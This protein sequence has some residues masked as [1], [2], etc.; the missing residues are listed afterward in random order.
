VFLAFGVAGA[1]GSGLLA[2]RLA[3]RFGI[4]RALALGS[5]LLCLMPLVLLYR[6]APAGSP[7]ML[8][9]MAGSILFVT[10]CYGPAFAVIEAEL[11]EL[12]KATVTG[13][14]MLLINVLM[15]GG[16]AVLIGATSD[17]LLAEGSAASW[18]IPL[19]AADLL[20]SL[21]ILCLFAAARTRAGSAISQ[22]A[23]LEAGR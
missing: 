18:T 5:A 20:A 23:G 14:N 2:D 7:V 13:L 19:L 11:P 17:R 22:P 21:G 1:S 9:G 6:L 16:L 15:L 3:A 12:L 4:D 10:G 8:A